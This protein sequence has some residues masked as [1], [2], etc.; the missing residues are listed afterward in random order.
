VYSSPQEKILWGSNTNPES[1]IAAGSDVIIVGRGIYSAKDPKSEAQLYRN[2]G[3]Q[4]LC[5]FP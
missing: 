5:P 2:A 4:G 1:V 3:W